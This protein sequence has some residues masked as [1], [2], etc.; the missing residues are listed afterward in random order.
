M[1]LSSGSLLGFL[2][3]VLAVAATG[4]LFSARPADS[5]SFSLS[6]CRPLKTK[7]P[8]PA[9]YFSWTFLRSRLRRMASRR[10]RKEPASRPPPLASSPQRKTMMFR[11]EI[12]AISTSEM[13]SRQR[14]SAAAKTPLIWP[15]TKS[16][17]SSPTMPPDRTACPDTSASGLRLAS[18]A[19]SERRRMPKPV[20]L[21]T[22]RLRRRLKKK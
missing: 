8:S 19:D 3:T 9:S 21:L 15:L 6:V 10:W 22:A 5:L 4:A 7:F 11:I 20:P 16:L 13:P 1:P 14:K 12:L 2:M 18:S 17:I